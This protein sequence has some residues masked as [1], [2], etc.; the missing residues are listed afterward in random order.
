MKKNFI[1]SLFYQFLT[2]LLPFA[3][4]PYIAR[5]LGADLLGIYSKTHAVANYFY[6]FTI[7][8]VN[9]YGNRSIARVRD[10]QK[11]RSQ[12][13]WEIYSFQFI[14]SGTTFLLYAVFCLLLEHENCLI[15]ILQ[16]VYV[17][18]GLFEITWICNG[19]EEFRLTTIRSTV[20]K[21]LNLAAV[22]LFVHDKS[23]L[24]IYTAIL[25]SCSIFSALTVWPFVM[26]HVDFVRPTWAGIKKHIKPN[27]VLFW[28]VIAVSLYNIMD[29]LLLGYFSTN[30]EVAF[31]TN[32]E[33]IVTIPTTL[34][35]A[36]DHVVMPRMSNIFMKNETERAQKIMNCVM[37]LAMF[38]SAAMMFGVAGISNVF[39]PWFYGDDFTRCGYYILLLCPTILIKGWASALRTQFLIPTGRDRIFII[40]L[41]SGAVVNLILDLLLIPALDGVGAIAGTIA[42]EFTVAFLQFLMCRKDIPIKE[43]LKNGVAFVLI[44]FL[45]FL[46]VEKVEK[47]GF[48]ALPTLGL[49][50]ALG[51]VIYC[52]L[53][54]FY[55]VRI[56]KQP[57]LI[58]E[59]LKTLRIKYRFDE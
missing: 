19:M 56:A 34:I 54:C 53:G 55:M 11:L 46:C 30:E 41:T 35:L 49:Q 4:A 3:T 14:T 21:L 7:L 44:G 27:L 51:V 59:G 25:S 57:V 20:I 18:S 2:L 39:A 28:P 26:K 36:L 12:T 58:N 23:D 22:F 5:T 43:Y 1:Y 48:S 47:L 17:L 10:D 50:V 42:A 31:Y 33:R 45:M 52:V 15:Y 38:M 6:L 29:K 9:S 13:F 16:G 24:G 8:G 40:S 37:L 32:A